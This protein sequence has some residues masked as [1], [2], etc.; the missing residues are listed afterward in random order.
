MWFWNLE[1]CLFDPILEVSKTFGT[2][3][4]SDPESLKNPDKYNHD[5]K[6]E[7]IIE[8]LL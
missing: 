5:K 1:R 7:N 8:I 6:I 2:I 4:Y 3:L